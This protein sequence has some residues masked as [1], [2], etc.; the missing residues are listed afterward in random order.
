MQTASPRIERKRCSDHCEHFGVLNRRSLMA[1][2]RNTRVGIAHGGVTLLRNCQGIG[3]D[4]KKIPRGG[5]YLLRLE[6]FT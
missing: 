1:S 3:N 5:N 4:L 6:Y 2:V